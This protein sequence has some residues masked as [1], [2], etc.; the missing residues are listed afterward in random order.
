MSPPWLWF[1]SAWRGHIFKQLDDETDPAACGTSSLIFC[2]MCTVKPRA[3][4]LQAIP[5]GSKD[6]ISDSF[7]WSRPL[8][9][10]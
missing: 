1:A 8:L 5:K 7:S 9:V 4:R 2:H 3:V 6:L 10:I